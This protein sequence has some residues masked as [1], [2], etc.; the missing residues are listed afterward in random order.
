MEGKLVFATEAL[1]FKKDAQGQLSLGHLTPDDKAIIKFEFIPNTPEDDI[2]GKTPQLPKRA[3]PGSAGLDLYSPIDTTVEY[4]KIT[5][6][7]LGLKTAIPIG[8][9]GRIAP[10]SG[11]AFNNGIDVLAGVIDQT[12]RQEV[13]VLLTSVKSGEIL[14]IKKGE[15]IAQLILEKYE[16]LEPVLG[17]IDDITERSG[18][19]GS[20]GK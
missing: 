13:G 10:R 12:F 3:E 17:I 9:Y 7:K 18:G 20:T 6:I 8:L 15:R 16:A 14:Q 5:L 4:G 19:F 1:I 11:L 2:L